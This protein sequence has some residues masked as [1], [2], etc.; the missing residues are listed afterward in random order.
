MW[1]RSKLK[2]RAKDVLSKHYWKSFVA[3]LI[4]F[5]FTIGNSNNNGK[6]DGASVW[7]FDW[8]TFIFYIGIFILAIIVFF[9][10][11]VLLGYGLIVG[12]RKFFIRASEGEADLN[13]FKYAFKSG[14][15]GNI[16]TTML[17]RS[18]LLFLWLLCFIFPFVIKWYAYRFVPYLLADNPELSPRRA[19]ELSK[20]MTRGEKF[21]MFVLDLS[22]IPWYILGLLALGLG[23]LFVHPYRDATFAELYLVLRDKLVKLEY[24]SAEEL[25]LESSKQTTESTD[26]WDNMFDGFDD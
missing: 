2:T 9:A 1:N 22:F 5:I 4:I 13:H 16:I 11:R 3:S 19:I 15:L 18:I 12:G 7:V 10:I 26:D 14:H 21:D 8:H 20:M 24:C 25:N 6:S 17:F 23:V